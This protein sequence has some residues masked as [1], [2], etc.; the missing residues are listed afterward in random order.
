MMVEH[1][2]VIGD[3]GALNAGTARRRSASRRGGVKDVKVGDQGIQRGPALSGNGS[4][5]DATQTY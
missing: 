1:G 4:K 2:G 3:S 5:V